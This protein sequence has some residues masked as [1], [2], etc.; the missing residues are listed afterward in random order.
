[1]KIRSFCRGPK[2]GDKFNFDPKR[3]RV[4][5]RQKANGIKTKEDHSRRPRI[6]RTVTQR[7]KRRQRLSLI[8]SR[9]GSQ[10]RRSSDL[11][12]YLSFHSSLGK[13]RVIRRSELKR[14]LRYALTSEERRYDRGDLESSVFEVC[15]EVESDHV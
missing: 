15:S 13:N 3:T 6:K 5:G 11:R 14:K 4:A 8:F 12:A 7:N 2:M 10:F 1:M 9:F